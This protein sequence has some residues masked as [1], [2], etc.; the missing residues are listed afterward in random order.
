MTALRLF[1]HIFSASIWVGGQILMA[2]LLP[3][4]RSL[5]PDVPR[6]FARAFN[7]VAW[8]AFG[9]AVLTGLWNVL[10]IPMVDLPHPWVELHVLAAVVTGAGAAI[11]TQVRASRALTGATM[12]VSSLAAV[13]TMYLG[14]VV[15][16]AAG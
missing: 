11:H 16:T 2:G 1:L 6:R 3:T 13:A 15:T 12:A 8:P 7:L 10:A 4:I 9:V 14:V 5:G